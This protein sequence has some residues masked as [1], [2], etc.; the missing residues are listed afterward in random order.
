MDLAEQQLKE[1]AARLPDHADVLEHLG[2][3]YAA[4]GKRG[5]A[6]SMLTTALEHATD[7]KQQKRLSG[8]LK[9]LK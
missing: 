9:Q 1:A 6:R 7:A 2:E 4:R 8:R 5:E 3:L